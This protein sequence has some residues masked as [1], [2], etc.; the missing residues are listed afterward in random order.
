MNAYMSFLKK[1]EEEEVV[2]KEDFEESLILESLDQ[3]TPSESFQVDLQ[4]KGEVVLEVLKDLGFNIDNNIISVVKERIS[5][6]EQEISKYE[7]KISE[8]KSKK[9]K[10][11]LFISLFE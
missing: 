5:E 8:L 10:Y 4:P 3:K 1:K 11:S 2:E 7:E 9:E 6:I